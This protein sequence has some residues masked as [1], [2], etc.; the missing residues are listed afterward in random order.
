MKLKTIK[1]SDHITPVDEVNR[2]FQVIDLTLF[3]GFDC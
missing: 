3:I 2:K 1:E